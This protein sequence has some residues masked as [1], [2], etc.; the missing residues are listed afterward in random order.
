MPACNELPAQRS[1]GQ[2]LPARAWASHEH[3]RSGMLP[4]A[5]R[6]SAARPSGLLPM[7]RAIPFRD[8]VLAGRPRHVTRKRPT[9][10]DGDVVTTLVAAPRPPPVLA[11]L[12]GRLVAALPDG[13]YAVVIEEFAA[14]RDCIVRSVP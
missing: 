6:E 8:P 14:S 10:L 9:D 12:G 1:V 4:L 5:Q 3:G 13:E 2:S 7:R 11:G